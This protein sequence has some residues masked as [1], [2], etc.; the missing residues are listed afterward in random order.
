MKTL[1][2]DHE[3]RGV[4]VPLTKAEKQLLEMSILEEGC[5][6]PIIVWN[7]TIVDGHNRYEICHRNKIDFKTLE[8][9]F[10]CKDEAIEWV[11]SNQLARRN[12]STW[13]KV[14]AADK[15]R[16]YFEKQ[17]QENKSKAGG[18]KKSEHA[19]SLFQESDKA[20]NAVH[21]DEEIAKLAGTSR[22]TVNKVSTILKNSEKHPTV[23]ESLDKGEISINKAHELITG[24]TR[25]T[26]PP[27]T[28][29][30]PPTLT[31][32]LVAEP[33]ATKS[34][35]ESKASAKPEKSTT[36]ADHKA[37]YR[38]VGEMIKRKQFEYVVEW[39]LALI[40]AD[41]EHNEKDIRDAIV[42]LR[43]AFQK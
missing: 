4:L 31:P 36:N 34:R 18:D 26:S 9:E 41:D 14:K 40:K 22:D 3:I 32:P 21:T 10:T 1:Q 13:E 28:P 11:V 39:A 20:I 25:S 15:L 5:R 38:T 30:P 7:G 2:I 29:A 23:V 33:N 42:Q 12:L 19:K 16:P 43:L 27:P 37:S 35:S 24:K 6:E 17:A 8:K